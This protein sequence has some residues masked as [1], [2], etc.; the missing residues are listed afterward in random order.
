M[1]R[2]YDFVDHDPYPNDAARPRHLRGVDDHRARRTTSTAW[3]GSPTGRRSCPCA[4]S[5]ALGA[6]PAGPIAR[7]MRWAVDHGANVIN[8]S[9]ELLDVLTGAPQSM[10]VDP[11]IRGAVRHA[12]AHGVVGRGRG[13]QPGQARRPVDAAR[14][15][16]HL[17]GREHRA[18]LPRRLLELRSRRRSRGPGRR[19]GRGARRRP[20]LQSGRAARA[21]RPCRSSFKRPELRR[22][23]VIRDGAGRTGLAGTSMAAPH[24]AATVVAPARARTCSATNPTPG[25]VQRRLTRTARDL[26]RRREAALLRC[27][28]GRRRGARCAARNA[29]RYVVRM[30]STLQGAWWL[31]LFGTEPSRK[32]LAPVIPLLPTTMRSAPRSSATSRMASAGSP[33]RA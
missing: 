27:R 6:G 9:I 4:S 10:T 31:T 13:R 33:W 2:G 21:Q 12:A 29:R 16:H 15:G 7:G 25:D 18:R 20:P 3:S 32:R 26:G 19:R 5:T 11:H 1:V 30:I 17:R 22:F 23:H 14:L 8:V 28:A 24:V